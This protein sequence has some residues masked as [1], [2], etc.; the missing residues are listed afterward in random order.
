MSLSNSPAAHVGE[1]VVRMMKR[2]WQKFKGLP[3]VGKV[4]DVIH[5]QRL[6]DDNRTHNGLQQAVLCTF[7]IFDI[8][9]LALIAF[10]GPK[11]ITQGFYDFGQKIAHYRYGWLCLG[12]LMVVLC[13][14]PLV[15]YFTTVSLCGF[16]YGVNGFF[17]AAPASVFGS[18]LAFVVLRF[19]FRERL[20]SWTAKNEKW[21][22]LENVIVCTLFTC[23]L[24][25][26]KYLST[27]SQR[28]ASHDTD[29]YFPVPSLGIP[30]RILCCECSTHLC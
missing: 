29:P 2:G 27:E 5:S 24:S 4:R 26:L 10:F 6:A 20:Q 25:R 15:F 3:L 23:P 11:A 13:F 28:P 12:A 18:A 7:V 16:T 22:A 21:Q 1:T 19:L 17:I 9:L 14:P 8:I 30:K